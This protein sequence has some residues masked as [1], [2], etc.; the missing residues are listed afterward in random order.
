LGDSSTLF[1]SINRFHFLRYGLRPCC[2]QTSV[3]SVLLCVLYRYIFICMIG[4]MASLD[5][6]TAVG[7]E[8]WCFSCRHLIDSVVHVIDCMGVR[9]FPVQ[10]VDRDGTMHISDGWAVDM[11]D[12]LVNV[13]DMEDGQVFACPPWA[14]QMDGL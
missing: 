2:V 4:F 6:D 5:L 12:G 8:V 3:P 9:G 14:V 13:Q 7:G 10:V 11:K 1:L